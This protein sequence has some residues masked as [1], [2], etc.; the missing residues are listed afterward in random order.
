MILIIPAALILFA[1]TL[2]FALQSIPRNNRLYNV[3]LSPDALSD[4][5]VQQLRKPYLLLYSIYFICAAAAITP[6]F[7]MENAFSLAFIY[8]IMWTVI[9][10][11]IAPAPLRHYRFKLT[12]LKRENNWFAAG[13]KLIFIEKELKALSSKKPMPHYWF[14]LPAILILP[15]TYLAAGNAEPLVRWSGIAPLVMTLILFLLQ[16]GFTKERVVLY[17]R[18]PQANMAIHQAARQYWSVLW[19]AIAIFEAINAYVAYYILSEGTSISSALWTCGIFAVSLVPLLAIY[20]TYHRIRVLEFRYAHTDGKKNTID[21]DYYWRSGYTYHN[22]EDKKVFVKKRIGSGIT[23]NTATTGGKWFYSATILF[24]SVIIVAVSTMVIRADLQ[25]PSLVIANNG[26]IQIED[27]N[28][29]YNF[30]ISDIVEINLEEKMPSGFKTNGIAVQQYARGNF[31]LQE[32]GPAKM[33]IF[34]NSSP[35]IVIQL[36]D[37]YVI[38]NEEEPEDTKQVFNEL[39]EFMSN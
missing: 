14:L 37:L 19:L 11:C 18:N 25:P 2:L 29:P 22:P 4:E 34:K 27:A 8:F 30:K 17:S 7:W 31:Q 24:I 33:Y 39:I 23:V 21:V 12:N 9:I 15:L 5:R 26:S 13:K 32:L 1:T 16:L 6:L 10:L 35:Y 38:Y 28:Y 36:K 20:W 3:T